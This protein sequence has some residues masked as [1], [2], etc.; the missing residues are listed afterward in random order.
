MPAPFT[1]VIV[2]DKDLNPDRSGKATPVQVKLFRLKN[3]TAFN[4]GDF[5]TLYEKEEQILGSELVS[6][7]VVTL[8]P[9]E[10]KTIL[11]KAGP[12]E[13]LLGV[14]VAYRDIEK[15]VWRGLAPLPAPKE[16]GRFSV[17]SPSFEA[18]YVTVKLGAN[19]VEVTSN[20]TDVPVPT[21]GGLPGGGGLPLNLPI[22]F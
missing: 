9:G 3:A 19:K 8:Q 10:T 13:R 1:V 6:K 7:E 15:S 11:G 14:F 16:L 22:R 4:G 12:E 21:G 20:I 18:S 17:F 2:A 5:F